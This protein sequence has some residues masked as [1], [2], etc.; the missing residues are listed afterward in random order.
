MIAAM[1][2]GIPRDIRRRCD[3]LRDPAGTSATQVVEAWLLSQLDIGFTASLLSEDAYQAL[4]E[5]KGRMT[6]IDRLLKTPDL[7][8]PNVR[9]LLMIATLALLL[10]AAELGEEQWRSRSAELSAF[11]YSLPVRPIDELRTGFGRLVDQ[12]LSAPSSSA[13]APPAASGSA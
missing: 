2:F 7:K 11:G 4:R 12:H 9:F 3:E 8:E 1:S 10:H 13:P 5:P 6:T